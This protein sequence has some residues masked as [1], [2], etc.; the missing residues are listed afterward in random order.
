MVAEGDTVVVHLTHH[1]RHTGE[2]MGMPPT[3]RTFAFAY[4]HIHIMKFQ[5]GLSIEH[6]AVRDDAA[7]MRQLQ[8]AEARAS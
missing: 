3:G 8:G 2:F 1:G 5:D 4:A 7:L 6:W